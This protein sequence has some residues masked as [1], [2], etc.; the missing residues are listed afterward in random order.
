MIIIRIPADKRKQSPVWKYPSTG[1]AKSKKKDTYERNRN[2]FND[3]SSSSIDFW[4]RFPAVFKIL[5]TNDYPNTTVF[6][7]EN[8]LLIFFFAVY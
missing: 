5:Y 2:N 6:I 1:D 7:N 3:A 4:M 8:I